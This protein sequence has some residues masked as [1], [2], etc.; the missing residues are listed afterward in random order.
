MKG[1]TEPVVF[2]ILE[3]LYLVLEALQVIEL[4]VTRRHLLETGHRLR[5]AGKV[6]VIVDLRPWSRPYSRIY[7]SLPVLLGPFLSFEVP[8]SLSDS[9]EWHGSPS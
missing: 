5:G 4:Q 2:G 6:D 3:R 8:Y 7:P 9:N 1:C